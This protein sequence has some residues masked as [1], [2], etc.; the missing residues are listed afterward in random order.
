MPT[1]SKTGYLVSI[2]G[3]RWV[4]VISERH[5]E[6]PSADPDEFFDRTQQLRTS[7][8]YDAIKGAR[9]LDG[10]HRFSVPE[11]SWQHYERLGDFPRGLLPIGDAICRFNPVYGQGMTIAAQEACI[12]RDMLSKRAGA[13]D[14]FAGLGQAFLAQIQPL[15]ADA[16]L[17]SAVPDFVHQRTRGEPP[18]D[19]DNSLRFGRGL[20]RLAGREPAIH[21]IMIG[22]RQLIEPR[23]ALGH[24][25]LVGRVTSLL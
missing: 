18:A 21:K 9:R 25:E 15:I 19:L 17:Q 4:V 13:R 10:I 23:S 6:M 11:N 22:V 5:I 1:S 2:E 8:I 24:P 16:W 3:N 14:P 20:L 12:L 7:T